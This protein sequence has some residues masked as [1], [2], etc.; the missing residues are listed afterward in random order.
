MDNDENLLLKVNEIFFSIQGESSYAGLPCL[1]V[2]LTGCNL[3]C[4]YCDTGYAYEEGQDMSPEEILGR[5]KT[6]KCSRVM[7]TG[8]EPLAQENVHA[9]M[10]LL[11][12]CGYVVFLETNGSIS[13]SEVDKRVV[14]IMD[15]KCP[16][17]GQS[18][19]NLFDNLEHLDEKDEIKFVIGDR[20]DYSWAKEIVQKYGLTRKHKVLFSPVFG[21]IENKSL[22]SWILEDA[23]D[24]RLQLQLHKLIWSPEMRG[25]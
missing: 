15:L 17:S 14:K 24:V 19:E 23:L 8:G 20:A 7:I 21:A 9:L 11:L 25:L 2:R 13:L 10:R 16:S 22:A 3:R 6:Y 5:L 1:F 4:S 12:D 18:G